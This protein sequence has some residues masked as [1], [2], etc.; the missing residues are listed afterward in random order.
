MSM[1]QL[2]LAMDY[3]KLF[4]SDT[5]IF[6]TVIYQYTIGKYTSKFVHRQKPKNNKIY[7]LIDA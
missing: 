4:D 2:L 3:D 7:I 5:E 1:V 6:T